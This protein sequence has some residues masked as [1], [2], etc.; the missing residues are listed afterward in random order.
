VLR[1][2]PRAA[3]QT[4]SSKIATD[5]FSA[6]ALSATR[7]WPLVLDG[8]CP[9]TPP[10]EQCADEEDEMVQPYAAAPPSV[11]AKAGEVTATMSREVK[12]KP[13]ESWRIK[14]RKRTDTTPKDRGFVGG[15]DN[16]GGVP[17]QSVPVGFVARNDNL[18][19]LY[20]VAA[21]ARPSDS[22]TDQGGARILDAVVE[23]V[24]WGSA[25]RTAS[26]PSRAAII[27]AVQTLLSGPFLSE[28]RQYGFRSVSLR[29]TTTVIQP[30]PPATFS[31][32]DVGDMV[33]NAIDSN[34]FPEPDD[35]GGRI[36][37]LVFMPSGTTGPSNA[38]G[39]HSDPSDFDLPFDTDHAWVGWVGAGTLDYTM[40]VFSHEL[41]E[42]ITDPEPDSPAWTMTRSINGG[43]EIGDACN[44]TVDR[45][46]GLLLQA[47]WSQEDKACVIPYAKARTMNTMVTARAPNHL[48]VFWIG[49]DG[50]VGTNWWDQNAN[51]GRWNAPFGIAPPGAAV[52]SAIACVARLQ[53]HLD[54]FWIGSDGGV[55]T[56]WWDQNANSGRWNAPFPIA[57]PGAAVVGTIACVA[58][59]QDHL[60]VFWIGPDGGVGTNWW[61]QN[62]NNGRWNTPFPIAPRSAAVAGGIAC[63]ARLQNHLDVFWVGPDGGIG[64]AWWDQNANNGQWNPPFPIAQP[65]T[66]VVGAVDCVARAPNHLDVFWIRPDGGVGTNWWDQNANGGKWNA[67]FAITPPG[68]AVAGAV[69]CVSRTPNHLDVFWIGPDG[70]VGTTWWDQNANNGKWN[71]PFPIT[72]PGAAAAGAIGAVS[73]TPNHLDAFWVGPD[74]AVGTTWWDQNANGGRWNTPFPISPPGSAV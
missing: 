20:N 66:A 67:P 71:T 27:G 33:W 6:S 36:L 56:N 15:L 39:A 8:G 7:Q 2:V 12:L 51:S 54:V 30:G 14:R 22:V 59:T 44:N 11:L 45:V 43:T 38:R 50:G 57:P 69:S 48:D 47:Y 72:P 60:D 61:D 58:R 68:A 26:N 74:G 18:V 1:A 63:V 41:V 31:T 29:G 19:A 49:P 40:D 34:V 28:L 16:A 55:G 70:A 9:P 52:A 24:F 32:S 25:W 23:L 73:R 17:P 10:E 62:A 37:Y 64:T 21:D 53:N 42:A 13:R 5:M 65:G 35:S 46:E 3:E 4:K